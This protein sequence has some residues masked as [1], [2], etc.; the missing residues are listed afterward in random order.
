MCGLDKMPPQGPFP[1]LTFLDGNFSDETKEEVAVTPSN[2]RRLRKTPRPASRNYTL[3]PPSLH[4]GVAF[5]LELP[6]WSPMPR[7]VFKAA[8]PLGDC[9]TSKRGRVSGR[10]AATHLEPREVELY[11]WLRALFLSKKQ[12]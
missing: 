5:C 7:I 12:W 9:S 1:V 6:T 4:T 3:P 10:N 2:R 8:Q 11:L